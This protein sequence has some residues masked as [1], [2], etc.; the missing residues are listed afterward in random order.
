MHYFVWLRKYSR[1]CAHVSV[2][3]SATLSPPVPQGMCVQPSVNVS[4]LICAIIHFLVQLPSSSLRRDLL[5]L[6]VFFVSSCGHVLMF[7]YSIV[8]FCSVMYAPKF[9]CFS[10]LFKYTC[11]CVFVYG[12]VGTVACSQALFPFSRRGHCHQMSVP[13][14]RGEQW[15][16]KAKG[17]LPGEG[18]H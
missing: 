10:Y 8:P 7:I 1:A 17:Q 5:M 13:G 6:L 3:L 11:M 2:S 18:Q 12:C 4:V 15:S 14:K 16:P 9:V